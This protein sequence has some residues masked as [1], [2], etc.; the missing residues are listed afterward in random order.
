MNVS[1]H[2]KHDKV[3][4]FENNVKRFTGLEKRRE[5]TEEI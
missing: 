1:S 5:K 2:L 3:F 4:S